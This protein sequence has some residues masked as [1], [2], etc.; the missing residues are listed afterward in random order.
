MLF[1]QILFPT[2]TISVLNKN[3]NKFELL[4]NE[5]DIQY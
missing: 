5:T 3:W 2:V 1:V 4:E